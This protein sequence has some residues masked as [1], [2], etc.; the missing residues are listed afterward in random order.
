LTSRPSTGVDGDATVHSLLRREFDE[1]AKVRQRAHIATQPIGHQV[2][3]SGTDVLGYLREN[4]RRFG[5]L[6]DS[7]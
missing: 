5:L 3:H 2:A 6:Q 1:E 4:A 7:R